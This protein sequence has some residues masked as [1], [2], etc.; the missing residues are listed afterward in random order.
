MKFSKSFWE[1]SLKTEKKKKK[2]Q[3]VQSEVG[4]G[5]KVDSM[6]DNAHTHVQKHIIF[7]NTII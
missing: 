7:L 4:K 1:L 3:N 2:P 6:S 5:I